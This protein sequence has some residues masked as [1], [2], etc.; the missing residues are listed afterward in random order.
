M[1][2]NPSKR[3]RE[4]DDVEN[5]EDE[6]PNP[7]V[8]LQFKQDTIRTTIRQRK[9]WYFHTDSNYKPYIQPLDILDFYVRDNYKTNT[10]TNSKYRDL[11]HFMR[12]GM[13]VHKVL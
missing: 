9:Y 8:C 4:D 2:A 10:I 11:L 12:Y 1:A 6:I 3:Q 5:R 13:K 7:Y